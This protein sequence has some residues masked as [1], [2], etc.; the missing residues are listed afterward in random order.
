VG[1]MIAREFWPKVILMHATTELCRRRRRRQ[2]KRELHVISRRTDITPVYWDLH[3]G[4]PY[5][6]V[7]ATASPH[8]VENR[9]YAHDSDLNGRLV[10]DVRSSSNVRATQRFAA[11]RLRRAASATCVPL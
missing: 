5:L 9:E 10:L 2:L 11:D 8:V 3:D 4:S 1:R 6:V 7:A